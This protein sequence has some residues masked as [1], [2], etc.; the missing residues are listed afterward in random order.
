MRP[1]P[2]AVLLIAALHTG[3]LQA[4]ETRV[5][6]M[7]VAEPWARASAGAGRT[8]AVY[9]TLHNKGGRGDRLMGVSTPVAKRAALHG[10]R[11]QGDMMRMYRAGPLA[12]PAGGT[13]A[14]RP[15]GLH[16]MLMGLTRRL[17]KGATFAMTLS[18]EKAGTVEVRVPIHGLGAMG[19]GGGHGHRP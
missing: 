14:L 3:P 16:V 15:G 17:E 10:H 8:G 6:D 5:G 11:M 2:V 12:L 7:V 19:P 1:M 9:L 13:V 4:A 18:F